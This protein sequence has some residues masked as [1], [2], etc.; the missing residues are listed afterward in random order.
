VLNG[1]QPPTTHR[2]ATDDEIG[3]IAQANS[4]LTDATR[5]E[6]NAAVTAV[7]DALKH[8]LIQSAARAQALRRETPLQHYREDGTLLEGVV[9]LAFQE[10]TPF[11]CLPVQPIFFSSAS[12]LPYFEKLSFSIRFTAFRRAASA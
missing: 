5:E 3:A 4:R 10:S 2:R 8:P 9:D 12:S 6:T 11:A 7:R 1:G